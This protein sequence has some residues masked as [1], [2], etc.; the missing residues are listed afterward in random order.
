MLQTFHASHSG[1]F[2]AA[3]KLVRLQRLTW[4]VWS[5]FARRWLSLSH[6]SLII[7]KQ[8]GQNSK[9][10]RNGIVKPRPEPPLSSGNCEAS[11]N[12]AP[13]KLAKKLPQNRKTLHTSPPSS[14]WFINFIPT[15]NCRSSKKIPHDEIHRPTHVGKVFIVD[16]LSKNR[17]WRCSLDAFSDYLGNKTSDTARINSWKK[18]NFP[19]L[20]RVFFECDVMPENC[21]PDEEKYEGL[22]AVN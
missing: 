12:A 3:A 19:M 8:K 9:S 18:L 2:L 16:M 6:R 1:H 21:F 10:R 11:P 15:H 22:C 5:K 17:S 14:S 13:G 20:A 4:F 7:G